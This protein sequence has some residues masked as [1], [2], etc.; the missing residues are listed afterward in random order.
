MP[1]LEDMLVKGVLVIVGVIAAG[2]TIGWLLKTY[3]TVLAVLGVVAIV[4]RLTWWWTGSQW[5]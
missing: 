4:G 1:S 2:E 5:F 3:G